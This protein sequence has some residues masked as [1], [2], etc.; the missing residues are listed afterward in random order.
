MAYK[1][2]KAAYENQPKKMK[3]IA[4]MLPKNTIQYALQN[5]RTELYVRKELRPIL[6]G[7]REFVPQVPESI[8][9]F[10]QKVRLS[11]WMRS[12]KVNGIL[13]IVDY[14]FRAFVEVAKKRIVL[15][16]PMVHAGNMVSNIM[17]LKM[18]GLT[19]GEIYDYMKEAY[20]GIMQYKKD[21]RSYTMLHLK[22]LGDTKRG[23]ELLRRINNNPVK[24]SIDAGLFSFIVEDVTSEVIQKQNPIEKNV[25]KIIDSVGSKISLYS[26]ERL[27]KQDEIVN[28][29][30]NVYG[31]D[32]T[33]IGKGLTMALQLSD[34][35]A[36]HAI[37]RK[38]KGT[39]GSDEA[40]KLANDLFID[41]SMNESK[42]LHTLNKYFLF[43]FNKFA[44]RIQRG[45]LRTAVDHPL[46]FTAMAVGVDM[47]DELGFSYGKAENVIYN[48]FGTGMFNNL[49]L[50]PDPMMIAETPYSIIFE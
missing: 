33:D 37:Y 41:Y 43:P 12:G 32:S 34:F 35:M 26:K 16:N 18:N 36:K 49:H 21:I 17:L 50:G 13:R 19:N 42:L 14:Y 3:E 39:L 24:E 22:G 1:L 6:F 10:G 25:Q 30:K 27:G 4:D 44:I 45:I 46:Y 31:T 9:V 47:A 40:V 38:Y 28:I 48:N 5:G 20:N 8:N 11:K 2:Q 29:V 23:K 7:Y 15:Y